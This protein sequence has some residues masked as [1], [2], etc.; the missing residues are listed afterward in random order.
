MNLNCELTGSPAITG[1]D[2]AA[3]E[4][5]E[6]ADFCVLRSP[7]DAQC[8]VARPGEHGTAGWQTLHGPDTAEACWAWIHSKPRHGLRF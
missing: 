7:L 2:T 6:K 1:V 8:M 3:T 5:T 4:V